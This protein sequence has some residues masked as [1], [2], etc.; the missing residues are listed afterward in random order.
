MRTG[1][2]TLTRRLLERPVDFGSFSGTEP[3]SR[4]YGY[5]RGSPIDRYYIEAFLEKHASDIRGRALEI[6]D[7]SYCRRFGGDR[8][9]RQEVLHVHEGAPEATIIGDLSTPGILPEAALDCFVFT[10]TLHLIY[11]MKAALMEAHRGLAPGGVMLA[12]VPG[13]CPI[14]FGEWGDTWYWSLTE[15]SARRLFGE[16]FGPEN[17]TT[18]ETFGNVF[19]ATA[20]IQGVAVEEVRRSLLDVH[21]RCYPVVVCVRAVRPQ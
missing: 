4:H 15:L 1:L 10:Q 8:I 2:K 18:V 21:D 13:I 9:Q 5:D 19:A 14:A 11:D 12:T 7:A 3:I 16:V 17:V 20:F 6:G